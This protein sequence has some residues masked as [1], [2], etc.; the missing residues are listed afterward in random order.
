MRQ[1]FL[2]IQNSALNN[3]PSCFF[4]VIFFLNFLLLFCFVYLSQIYGGSGGLVAK[5]CLTLET[6][7]T[8]VHQA[9]LSMGFSQQEHSSGLPFP[10]PGDLPESGIEPTSLEF[11]ALQANSLS[12]EPP[13]KPSQ[14]YETWLFWGMVIYLQ[15]G[16]MIKSKKQHLFLKYNF[17]CKFTYKCVCINIWIEIFSIY[18]YNSTQDLF[19]RNNT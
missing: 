16:Q 9:P 2:W 15:V 3:L 14:A 1:S 4:W 10:S 7:W 17:S 8:V 19:L 5:L 18:L 13:G 12:T 11:P 6:L